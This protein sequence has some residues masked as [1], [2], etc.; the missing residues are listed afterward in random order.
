MTE[1]HVFVHKRTPCQLWT[2][3][4]G[5]PEVQVR[6]FVFFWW[7]FFWSKFFFSPVFKTCDLVVKKSFVKIIFPK[8]MFSICRNTEKKFRRI[9]D[10]L[11]KYVVCEILILRRWI[12]A[13]PQVLAGYISM[14][15]TSFFWR[16]KHRTN[17]P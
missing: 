12:A 15:D 16:W 11:W 2:H 9:N 10:F 1:L 3:V 7:S 8:K 13:L 17:L 4:Y 14:T 5:I 6:H